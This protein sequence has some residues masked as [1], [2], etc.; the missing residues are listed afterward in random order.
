[1]ITGE[2]EKKLRELQLALKCKGILKTKEEIF[3]MMIE[4][5]KKKFG[6]D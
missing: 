1:M 3:E 6:K 2:H 4:L 5:V